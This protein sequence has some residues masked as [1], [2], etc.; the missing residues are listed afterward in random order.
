MNKEI[1][2]LELFFNEPA[3]HWHFEEIIKAVKISRPQATNWLK[4]FVKAHLIKK[5][6]PRGK[7][8]YYFGNYD[9]P[10]YRTKKRLFALQ[11]MGNS[12]FLNHLQT[13][14]KAQTVI[15]FGSLSRWDWYKDS[16]ID[17]FIFGSDEELQQGTY[18]LKLD[19]EIQVFTAKNKDDFKKFAPGLLRN[20]LE[21]YRVKGTLD[22]VEVEAHA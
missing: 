6:K 5:V 12:G 13:L 20:I 16:D 18:E 21:G 1:P 17:L 14:K 9:H 11:Q 8:P 2:V 10:N 22:F 4:T 7:M 19:R 3:K 15:I